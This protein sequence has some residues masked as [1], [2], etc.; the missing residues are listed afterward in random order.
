LARSQKLKGFFSHVLSSPT[1]QRCEDDFAAALSEVDGQKVLDIGCGNGEQSLALLRTGAQVVGIDITPAYVRTAEQ[2]AGA[3]G[4][5]KTLWTFRVMDAHNLEF[6]DRSFDFVVGR[7]ILHHLDF[8]TALTEVRRVLKPGGKAVFLEP[9]SANPLLKLFRLLTPAA[10][11]ADERPLSSADLATA[12]N[13]WKSQSAFYGIV[14]TPVAVMTSFI[15]RPYPNNLLL[16][17]ADV[18][19]QSINRHAVLHR[20]NQ[21]VLL[22]LTRE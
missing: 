8:D 12:T 9:L 6:D 10:R 19:E 3:E 13:G 20:F 1:M 17:M 14:A 7:G 22:K 5:P 18:V 4:F 21:Y 16:R 11:T 2:L 15:L